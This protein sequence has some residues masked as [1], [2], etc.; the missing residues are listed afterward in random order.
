MEVAQISCKTVRTQEDV[1]ATIPPS[2]FFF[3]IRGIETVG[4]QVLQ[5][6][7]TTVSTLW[8]AVLRLTQW[9]VAHIQQV[10]RKQEDQRKRAAP[11]KHRLD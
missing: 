11:C 9:V 2:F 10:K 6:R 4:I 7:I 8:T 5:A 3:P 1:R